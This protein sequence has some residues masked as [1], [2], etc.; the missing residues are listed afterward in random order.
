MSQE[1]KDYPIESFEMPG[2]GRTETTVLI[3]NPI[4]GYKKTRTT[5]L[6]MGEQFEEEVY[7]GPI[8]SKRFL[9]I[10]PQ[11]GII[12]VS[13]T[14]SDHNI[15]IDLDE[16]DNGGFD[17]NLSIPTRKESMIGKQVL[18]ATYSSQG[19]LLSIDLLPLP[20]HLERPR[21]KLD[22]QTKQ[23]L[24]ELMLGERHL[25]PDE[26]DELRE[27]I[28]DPDDLTARALYEFGKKRQKKPLSTEDYTKLFTQLGKDSIPPAY[29]KDFTEHGF[30]YSLGEN[31]SQHLASYDQDFHLLERGFKLEKQPNFLIVRQ[32]MLTSGPFSSFV[33]A[34]P[35]KLP[36]ETRTKL[37]TM[38]NGWRN[39][40]DEIGITG[41]VTK[42]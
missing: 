3:D 2:V 38:D 21:V 26:L 20:L 5:F 15:I 25:N 42:T 30:T 39:L 8:A 33:A 22:D 32:Q 34:L 6:D 37:R 16:T 24:Q 36:S 11:I 27:K 28:T 12:S 13:V 14:R 23:I 40:I 4:I 17:A 18:G 19:S 1:P 35:L 29:L 10:K 31:Y 9:K 41:S 7:E